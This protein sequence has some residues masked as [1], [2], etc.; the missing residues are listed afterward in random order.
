MFAD[1]HEEYFL[2]SSCVIEL[3]AN[4]CLEHLLVRYDEAYSSRLVSSLNS[5]HIPSAYIEQV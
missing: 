4:M 5:D 3:I 1:E 2:P